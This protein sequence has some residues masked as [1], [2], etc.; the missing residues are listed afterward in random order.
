MNTSLAVIPAYKASSTIS[1][2]IRK[3]HKV[4]DHILVI[5]DSCPDGTG[6]VVKNDYENSHR[7]T[8]EF[9]NLNG[10]VGAAMKTGF[11]WAMEKDF[12]VIVKVDADDQMDVSRIPEMIRTIESG[13]A[14]MV[15]GNRFD[16]V[17]DLERMP[18]LRILGNAGLS[19]IAKSSSGLWSINDPTNGFFAISRPAL[20]AVQH[21]K[22][23]NGFFFES[24]LLFRLGLASC[25]VHELTMPAIYGSEKSNLKISRVLF[26]FP[27]LHA[28]NTMKRI[29]YKYF[30]REWSL[31]TLNL[32]GAFLMF[33]FAVALGIDALRVIQTTGNAVTAGQAVGV[34]LTAILGFQLLLA[35]LSYDVQME[36][37]DGQRFPISTE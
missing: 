2:V 20:E 24:D 21:K 9:R 10:G 27:F 29:A 7:V 25:K 22:L 19:L 12:T 5:D 26:T 17:R 28:K 11:D 1:E 23:S 13:E 4:V 3:L 8:V 37:R 30:V 32:L 15:K 14:D 18:F 34:S 31:G 35:F 36:R 33:V 16:S 6:Q